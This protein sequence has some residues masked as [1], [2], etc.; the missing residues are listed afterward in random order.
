MP[1]APRPSHDLGVLFCRL[2]R[3]SPLH[4]ERTLI[5]CAVATT[6]TRKLTTKLIGSNL[7][8]EFT[9]IFSEFEPEDLWETRR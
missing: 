9:D 6:K 8:E 1:A 2:A 4:Q 5:I 3:P 7:G